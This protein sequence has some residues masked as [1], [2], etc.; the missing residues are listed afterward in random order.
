[1]NPDSIRSLF[2]RLPENASRL[3]SAAVIGVVSGLSAVAFML[4]IQFV[5][6]NGIVRLSRMPLPVFIPASLAIVTVSCLIVGLLLWK[7][8]PDSSGSGI[9]QLKTAFWK[10]LGFIE[11]RHAVVKFVAGTLSIGGGSSMGRMGPSVYIG[12]AVASSAAGLLGTPRH[13][14]RRA[15]LM[16]AAAALAAAFNTPIAAITFVMEE[17]LNDLKG[18]YLGSIVLSAVLGAFVVHAI[19][20]R[21]PMYEM[22]PFEASSWHVYALVPVVA[23]VGAS[24]AGVFQR[25]VLAWRGRIRNRSRIPAYL[26]PLIGGLTTWAI[27][28]AVFV[29]SGKLGVFG[30]GYSDLSDVFTG[31]FGAWQ[32]A[33][34][35]LLAKL[36]ATSACHSWGGCGGIFSPILMM[37]GMAGL[38][39]SG[40]ASLWMPLSD[41][42]RILLCA[43]GMSACFGSAVKAPLTA[44]LIVFEMTHQFTIVPAL[45]LTTLVSQ[46]VSRRFT[47]LNMYDDLL[48]QDGHDI[49]HPVRVHGVTS[50]ELVPVTAIA[51]MKPAVL[52]GLSPDAVRNTLAGHPYRRFPLVLNGSPAGF[53]TRQSLEGFISKGVQPEILPACTCPETATVHDAAGMLLDAPEGILAIA[54]ADG[55]IRGILTMHDLVRA[56]VCAEE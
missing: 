22:P 19:I 30:L 36:A 32:A 24:I 35:L 4:C 55:T 11:F 28:I 6:D 41:A 8:S 23:A 52:D 10:D 29:I 27:G 17:M 7:L 33:G 5:F 14:R 1:M 21:R 40:M 25:T 42:D 46:A 15:L 37:G 54:G 2:R 44:I 12:G 38:F 34:L 20:G 45:M 48:K 56:Q 31:R 18:R 53:V 43:C 39:L 9:P 26:Q 16:G 50:W 13:S 3:I 47:A 49:D 51:S